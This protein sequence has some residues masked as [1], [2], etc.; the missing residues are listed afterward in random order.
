MSDLRHP[1][2]IALQSFATMPLHEAATNLLKVLGYS[3]DRRLDLGD[4]S[5]ETFVS[6]IN[7]SAPH[8]EFDEVKAMV[9]EWKAVHLLF[10]LT[11]QELIPGLFRD[12]KVKV[13]LLR[14]YVFIAIDLVDGPYPRGRLTGIAR[15]I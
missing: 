12:T 9:A 1:I 11:D 6:F 4:S 10:Q 8:S 13:G 3:S 5:P 15:Q 14:S 2:R 7:E